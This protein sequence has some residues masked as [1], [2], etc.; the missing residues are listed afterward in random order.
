MY[1]F[2]DTIEASESALLPSEAL[3][4]N[5]K[6]IENAI[7]GYRTL[8]VS[9]REALSPDVTSYE[10][11]VRDGSNLQY[12]R[13]PER[14]IVVEYQLIAETNEAFRAAYNELGSILD[15]EN[16]ELIFNDE[17]DKFFVGT[18]CII[19]RVTPGKNAV[20]GEFEIL[21]TDPFKYSVVEYEAEP[22]PGE[23]TIMIDYNGTYKSFPT[24]EA[25]FYHE[26]EADFYQQEGNTTS[27]HGM[28]DCGY[29]AFFNEHKKIIQ[30]GD[31]EETDTETYAKSQTLT[32]WYFRTSGGWGNNAKL[33]WAANQGSI[34][35]NVVDEVGTLG[36]KA[37]EYNN[38]EPEITTGTILNNKK[39]SSSA[40]PTFYY[41]VKAKA[42][43]R[44][45]TAV[46]V[47]FS[48]TA[49]M[50]TSSNYFGNGLGLV[51]SIYDG[52]KW[53]DVTLKKTS[54]YWK[55]KS[56]HT[57]NKTI[58]FSGLSANTAS[59]T[60]L[61]FKVTRSDSYGDAGKLSE[62]AC[63]SLTI[64][65]Y[66]APTPSAYCLRCS[67]YGTGEKWHGASISR[68]VPA[69]AAGDVGATN[70]TFSYIHKL[71]IGSGKNA[72]KEI[73]S[74]QVTLTDK[75]GKAVAGVIIHKNS[76]GKKGSIR[77][78]VNNKIVE[79]IDADVSYGNKKFALNKTSTI[80]KAGKKVTFNIGGTK[81]TFS[82]AAIAS[83]VVTKMTISMATYGT[84][85][86]LSYNGL[87]YVKF[88]KNNCDTFEDISNKF[89][90]ND[91]VEANCKNGEILLNG[92]PEPMYGALGND[93][94]EFYLTPGL[95]QIGYSYSDWVEDDYAPTVK[96]RYREVFL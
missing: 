71:S 2:V 13:Y 6:Y 67:D 10:T 25:A 56:G 75:N 84:N 44:T 94:E 91:I 57:V 26:D 52:S 36:M 66:V 37:Y 87:Y 29:V 49:S 33:V 1:N 61:K 32:N 27:A 59:L 83:A 62:T 60:G 19:G 70:F 76:K 16:A 74:F 18:P 55:G 82:N 63:N 43:D 50:G 7:P 65:K 72:D 68:A 47:E 24:L 92:V 5:G 51:A 64:S 54:A 12:K 21:C 93:W 35:P 78:I 89:S 53:H 14:I 41:T 20:V 39:S 80:T 31:P 9:G 77:F 48:I 8:S 22:T 58:T 23:S 30:L 90:A 86:P 81:K 15:V 42:Y 34:G 28:G 96:V 3:R 79:K 88:V 69:D 4:I 17:P 85:T 45:E 40:A 95:N 73:G 46:K 11:G 38:T